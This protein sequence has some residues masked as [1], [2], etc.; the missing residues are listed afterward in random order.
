ML[1]GQIPT[2]CGPI[3]ISKPLSHPWLM[4]PF[5]SGP[6]EPHLPQTD[7]GKAENANAL[8]K[9][10]NPWLA[11][12]KRR[13]QKE[14]RGGQ[15]KQSEALGAGSV[16]WWTKRSSQG[17]WQVCPHTG[18]L[19]PAARRGW[20]F[21]QHMGERNRRDFCLAPL[22]PISYPSKLPQQEVKCPPLLGFICP[23][24]E[25][26]WGHIWHKAV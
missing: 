13:M 22:S 3:A 10:W 7:A 6:D 25:L 16:S 4:A 15:A 8:F 2:P 26:L 24:Q 12:E 14:G 21:M 19:W 20:A 9:K 5:K 11:T 17:A 23:V 1:P 18:L